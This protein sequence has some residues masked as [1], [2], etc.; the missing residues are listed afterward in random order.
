MLETRGRR[1]D[2]RKRW[3]EGDVWGLTVGRRGSQRQIGTSDFCEPNYREFRRRVRVEVE[4]EVDE[5]VPV[6]A[7]ALT[8]QAA[9][10]D[11]EVTVKD[12]FCVGGNGQ[13]QTN[14]TNR[15]KGPPQW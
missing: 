3:R 7:D 13:N 15:A 10:S 8:Q 12:T 4:G 5:K 11:S 1:N 2:E 6:V 14:F 9:T